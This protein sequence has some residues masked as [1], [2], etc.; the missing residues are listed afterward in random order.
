MVRSSTAPGTPRLLFFGP[1]AST[2]SDADGARRGEVQVRPDETIAALSR[3]LDQTYRAV[4]AN[5]P[6][7]PAARVE[8]SDGKMNWSSPAGRPTQS[9]PSSRGRK[10]SAPAGGPT[11]NPTGDRRTHGMHGEIHACERA[12]IPRTRALIQST[13]RTNDSGSTG[14]HGSQQIFAFYRPLFHGMYVENV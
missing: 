6:T 13:R 7:N 11:G 12:R 9:D 14:R 8:T 4:A 2:S 10:R 5:L 3:Q 1:Q